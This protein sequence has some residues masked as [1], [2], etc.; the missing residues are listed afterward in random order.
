MTALST[1]SRA[2]WTP[3]ASDDA[4]LLA[5]LERLRAVGAAPSAIWTDAATARSLIHR[6][7]DLPDNVI[8]FILD[9]AD[10]LGEAPWPCWSPVE[11][12]AAGVR[13]VVIFGGPDEAARRWEDRGRLRR[14][15]V[16]IRSAPCILPSQHWDAWL[17]EQDDVRRAAERGIQLDYSAPWPPRI[18][19][20]DVRLLDPL[21]EH[22]PHGGRLLE[23]GPGGG[24]YTAPLLDRSDHMV[25]ADISRRLLEES[26]ERRFYDRLDDL[27]LLHDES[28]LLEGVRDRTLD[29][30]FSVDCFV[31][32][33]IDMVHVYM[34]SLARLLKPGARALLHLKDWN[35]A[36]IDQ[37][38][39]TE[40]APRFYRTTH[41]AHP[42]MIRAS[43]DRLGFEVEFIP[44]YCSSYYA[45]LT[46]RD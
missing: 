7:G 16:D 2:D 12:V 21:L 4:H 42:D 45:A 9:D 8:G 23:I 17:I 18:H 40:R 28:A 1:P 27:T 14:A 41:F 30:A 5:T 19:E 33:K 6:C 37:W 36:E 24:L 31:H 46:R 11:A 15:G 10:A 32:I 43:A 29:G 26:L 44:I 22:L 3:T 38:D 13:G 25:L 39:R 34:R 20:P 35:A